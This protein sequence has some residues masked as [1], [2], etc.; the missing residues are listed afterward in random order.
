MEQSFATATQ[1]NIDAA[2]LYCEWKHWLNMF[3]IYALATKLT[4]K[5]NPIQRAT[6]LHCLGPAVQTT[7]STLPGEHKKLDEAKQA[8]IAQKET[9]FLNATSSA[10]ENRGQMRQLTVTSLPAENWQKHAILAH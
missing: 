10:Q 5:D 6:L 1:F 7:F 2:D 4:K 8:Y 9:W 3:E